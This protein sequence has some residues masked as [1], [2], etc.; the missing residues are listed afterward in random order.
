MTQPKARKPHKMLTKPVEKAFREDMAAAIDAG[1]FALNENQHPDDII[2]L[3]KDGIKNETY[4]PGLTFTDFYVALGGDPSVLPGGKAEGK[5]APAEP[6]PAGAIEEALDEVSENIDDISGYLEVVAKAKA[7]IA[8]ATEIL[9]RAKDV[10][11]ARIGDKKHATITGA[12]GKPQIVA[13]LTWV[14]ATRFDKTKLEAENPGIVERY[15]VPN[16][17]QRLDFK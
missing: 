4:Q 14:N 3:V 13:S 7:K 2:T 12:D 15:T 10:I 11:K 9:D 6:Q 5:P 17:H 8:E 1:A 16:P